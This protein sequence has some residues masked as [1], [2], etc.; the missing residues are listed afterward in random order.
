MHVSVTAFDVSRLGSERVEL[1][2][3]K[4][5]LCKTPIKILQISLNNA[6]TNNAFSPTPTLSITSRYNAVTAGKC[7][8]W[9][10]KTD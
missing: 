8:G 1:C 9:C 6:E 7:F 4:H 5:T 3:F 10:Y 2:V